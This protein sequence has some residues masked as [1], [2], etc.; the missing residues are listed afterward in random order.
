MLR[1]I[2][3]S[4]VILAVVALGLE[5]LNIHLS[6]KLASS[7]ISVRQIQNQIADLN[8]KNQI[9]YSK[10]LELTSFESVSSKAAELGFE[11]NHNYISLRNQVKISYSK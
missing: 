9:L 5:L 6:S 7:S 2:Y 1:R 10:V 11:E 4:V 8:E 3:L